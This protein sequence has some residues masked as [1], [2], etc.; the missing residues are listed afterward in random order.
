MNETESYTE[1]G[2]YHTQHTSRSQPLSINNEHIKRGNTSPIHQGF[3]AFFE[4][5]QHLLSPII[6]NPFL[7]NDLILAFRVGF[8]HRGKKKENPAEAWAVVSERQC[9]IVERVWGQDL[10][11]V[12][13]V[14]LRPKCVISLQ[15]RFLFYLRNKILSCLLHIIFQGSREKPH[16]I[17]QVNCKAPHFNLP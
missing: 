16:V 10:G 11:T 5:V 4:V 15:L 12:S 9:G 1:C 6:I 7:Q 3:F 2:S 13:T 14:S 8:P 17:T